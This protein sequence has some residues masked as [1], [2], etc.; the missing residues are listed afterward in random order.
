MTFMFFHL[1]SLRAVLYGQSSM[2]SCGM[3]QKKCKYQTIYQHTCYV[4][5]FRKNRGNKWI[6]VALKNHYVFFVYQGDLV[7]VLDCIMS[8]Y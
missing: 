1:Q 5:V 7:K 2:W 4:S 3:S 8:V 6:I